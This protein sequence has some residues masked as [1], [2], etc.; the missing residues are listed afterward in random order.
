MGGCTRPRRLPAQLSRNRQSR[1]P[2]PAHARPT[3]PARVL[4]SAGSLHRHADERQGVRQQPQAR[5]GACARTPALRPLLWASDACRRSA[6]PLR[7]A[8]VLLQDR[9][10]P[11]DQGCVRRG[12]SGDRVPQ[13]RPRPAAS[14]NARLAAALAGWDEGVARMSIGQR[15][16]LTCSPDYAYGPKGAPAHRPPKLRS[17]CAQRDRRGSSSAGVP[18][19]IPPNATLVFDVELFE[20]R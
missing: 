16:K 4:P 6:P 13:R 14:T 11:G 12:A 18:G 20:V 3:R 2:L 9:S 7:R 10:G 15:A 19:A 5:R 17:L 1:T 8:E